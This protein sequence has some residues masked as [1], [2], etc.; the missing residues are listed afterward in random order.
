MEIFMDENVSLKKTILKSVNVDG[1]PMHV[2]QE[3]IQ[4]NTEGMASNPILREWYNRDVFKKIEEKFRAENGLEH[5]D[6]MYST[7]TEI[8]KKWQ[9]DG[10]IRDDI[11]SG[12]IMALFTAVIVID[13]HK[14]EV[15]FE[16][17]P[18]IQEYLTEFIINGL[19]NW[20]GQQTPQKKK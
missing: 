7:F 1:E 2:I 20:S 5:V 17:F 18:Q 15:G 13:I 9:A 6:F 4:K 12:M 16:Y 3:I 10:K 8:I 14:D 11:D 19:T